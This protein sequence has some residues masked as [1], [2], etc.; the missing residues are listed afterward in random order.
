[1]PPIAPASRRAG[2][3][4]GLAIGAAFA[5]LAWAQGSTAFD[6]QYMGQL[7]LTKTVSGDCTEP[8]PGALYP[9]AISGGRVEFKYVPRFD[10]ILQGRV[11]ESGRFTAIRRLRRGRVTMTGRIHGNNVTATINS[12]SCNY[13]FRTQN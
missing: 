12:P 11:D 9:L 5:G 13:T 7:T 10:T 3:G 4:L 6:G 1:M 2:L 8:P